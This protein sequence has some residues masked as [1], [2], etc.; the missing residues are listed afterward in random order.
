MNTL[1]QAAKQEAFDLI[2]MD[3]AVFSALPNVQRA[4]SPLGQTHV[5]D[6]SLGRKPRSIAARGACLARWIWF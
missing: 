1:Q 5:V 4:W 2:Y 6:A 3:G